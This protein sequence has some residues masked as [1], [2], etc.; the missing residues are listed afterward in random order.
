MS[1]FK[2]LP[3]FVWVIASANDNGMY[4]IHAKTHPNGN[5]KT[6]PQ[7]VDLHAA[8]GMLQDMQKVLGLPDEAVML[9]VNKAVTQQ[10]NIWNRKLK[11]FVESKGLKFNK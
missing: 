11:N 8:L 10:T 5:Y 3:D 7:E 6:Y 1:V 9:H 4:K 2:T